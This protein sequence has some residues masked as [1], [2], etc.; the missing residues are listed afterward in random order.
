MKCPHH[1]YAVMKN[2]GK[3]KV[4]PTG[5]IWEL[6]IEHWERQIRLALLPCSSST[7][8]AS[9]SLSIAETSAAIFF[10]S[11]SIQWVNES[12]FLI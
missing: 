6:F 11:T 7:H 5:F 2:K 10:A 8:I 1:I 3:N 12:T 9:T 4:Y